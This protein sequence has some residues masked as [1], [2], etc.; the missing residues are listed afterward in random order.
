[1]AIAVGS[2]VVASGPSQPES[3]AG[4]MIMNGA[5]IE[6]EENSR[7]GKAGLGW[8]GVMG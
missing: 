3:P 2:G 8:A 1:M 7:R 6:G 4:A 5:R